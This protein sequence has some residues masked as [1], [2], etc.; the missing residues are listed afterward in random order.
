[1]TK[2]TSKILHLLLSAA[3]PPTQSPTRSPLAQRPSARADVLDAATPTP[4][5]LRCLAAARRMRTRH[6]QQPPGRH[7]ALSRQPLTFGNGSSSVQRKRQEMFPVVMLRWRWLGCW[8]L[9][10]Y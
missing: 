3:P 7:H 6:S 10:S 4:A 2:E 1:M 8:T 5:L 9:L